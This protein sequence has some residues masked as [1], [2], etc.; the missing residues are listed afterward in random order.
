MI[1][2]RDYQ[3]DLVDKLRIGFKSGHRAMLLQLATGGG[4]CLGLGTPIIMFDGTIKQVENIKVGELLMGPDSTPRKVLSLARGKENLYKINQLNG[5]PY[6]VNE[7][8][9]LSLKHTNSKEVVNISVR[10][11]LQKNK[12][13]KH[14]MKSYKAGVEFESKPYN[15][16]LP[17]YLLGIWLG[18]GTSSLPS[19][20]S[21]DHEVID[22]LYEYAKSKNID[23]VKREQKGKVITYYI[24]DKSAIQGRGYH[25]NPLTNALNEYGL[26][27]NKHI[28][29]EYKC[30]SRQVRLQVLAGLI[31][32]DGHL[33]N[34]CY[35]IAF[36]QKDLA[37]DTVY[38]ARSLGL[39]AHIK[40]CKKT[41]TNTGAIGDYFRIGISGNLDIIPVKVERRKPQPRRQIKDSLVC[42]FTIEPLGIGDYYGFEIDGNHLFMLGDFTVTHNTFTF[43]F[44]ADSSAKKGGL[45]HILAHRSELV[46]QAS[47]SLAKLGVYH[48]LICTPAKRHQ[49]KVAHVRELNKCFIKSDTHVLVGSIQTAIRRKES[50]K[51]PTL[52]ILDEAHHAIAGQWREYIDYYKNARV[53][54]VTATPIRTDGKGLGQVFNSMVLGPLHEYLI[55]IGALVPSEIYFPVHGINLS[56]LKKD[57]NG[58][59]LASELNNRLKSEKPTICGDAVEWYRKIA[60]GKKAVVFCASVAGAKEA[61]EAF[62]RAG[63]IFK[64]LDGSME[65][66]DRI[67]VVNELASGKIHGITSCDIVSEGFDC[68]SLDVAILLRPTASESLYLQQVGRVL[69]PSPGKKV[70]I[71]IDHVGNVENFGAPEMEREWTLEGGNKKRVSNKDPEIKLMKT[72]EICFRMSLP[73]PSCPYCGHVFKIK[74]REIKIVEGELVKM[75]P[76]MLAELT[77]KKKKR[78]EVGKAKSLEELLIIEKERGYKQGWAKIIHSTRKNYV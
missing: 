54:G 32:T 39:R 31:D 11:Y 77:A 17:P 33:H 14:E 50:L 29:H 52:I 43:S 7:S 35:D 76:E 66:Y 1:V 5:D 42:G 74:T 40:P 26:I 15:Q 63:Y 58:E 10:D 68:P 18:D 70:G 61:A 49:V 46:T 60:D 71:I 41:C 59:Y 9:I 12:S 64:S 24:T 48:D 30:N 36:K 20:T 55:K 73:S 2:L 4:K 62:C 69:R 56:G 23:V 19:V 37:Y 13:F 21:V 44:I 34:N 75:T 27:N 3:K 25:S 51:D 72:C 6:T 67:Q 47:L 28:P 16:D 53:L 38:L 8:H 22:Y 65:D 57:K 45:I 78:S